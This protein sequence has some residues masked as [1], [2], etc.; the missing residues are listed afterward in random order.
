MTA[1]VFGS[2]MMIN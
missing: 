1:N 2:F